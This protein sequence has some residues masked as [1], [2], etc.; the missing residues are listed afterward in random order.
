M[1]SVYGWLELSYQ[2]AQKGDWDK[3]VLDPSKNMG[4]LKHAF[5]LSFFLLLLLPN[6]TYDRCVE[7]AINKAGDTDTNGAIVGGMIG[8][9]YGRAALPSEK[10]NLVLN[11]DLSKSRYT[12]RP[13][14]V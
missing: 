5:V 9:Y 4:F 7:E 3:S 1:K 14:E 2:F 6:A 13:K 10:V 11:C 8:A 12:D